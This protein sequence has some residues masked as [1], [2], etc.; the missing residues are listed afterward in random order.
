MAS[1]HEG[2][3][4]PLASFMDFGYVWEHISPSN[5]VTNNPG[6]SMKFKRFAIY[7]TPAPGPFADFGSAWLG[8]DA[9]KGLAPPAPDLPDLPMSLEEITKTPR[10]Y[11]LHATVMPPFRLASGHEE[12]EIEAALEEFCFKHGP[13]AIDRLKTMR[14]GRFLALVPHERNNR[15]NS[16][17][18]AAVEGFDAFRAPP[19][20]S[21]ILKRGSG[22]LSANQRK[23]LELWG[24]PYVMDEFRFHITLTS[25][26]PEFQ[27]ERIG[28][29][30]EPLFESRLPQ[31]FEIDALSLT[32]ESLD[33]RF[34]LIRRC[35][36][37]GVNSPDSN[38]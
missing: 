7:F 30:I 8:W 25:K 37:S 3:C 32:G 13:V 10:K 35:K 15:L 16:L 38:T 5:P 17:A 29:A 34:H 4:L 9:D 1:S 28:N 27:I 23:M 6:Q 11:G 12:S 33:D 22:G 14:M 19:A 20:E 31:P 2:N 26:L 18:A 21:E 36:L 24:Y